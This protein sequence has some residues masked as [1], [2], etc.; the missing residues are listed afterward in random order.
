MHRKPKIAFAGFQHETNTFAPFL[1]EFS[2]FETPGAWPAFTEGEP[3]KTIC[4]GLNVPISG[5]MEANENFELIPLTYAAAE[6]G[7]LVTK[8]AF[9]RISNSIIE[10][11]KNSG[12]LDGLYFDLH[13][14]MVTEGF[15]DGEEELLKRVR[16]LVGPKMPIVASLD[17]HGNISPK[18]I[19]LVSAV[20]I[21]RT[22]PHID[23]A[24]TGRRAAALL[25]QV[26]AA[27]AP[28]FKAF[29]QANF[30]IPITAQ[31]TRR[32]PAGELYKKLSTLEKEGV[33]SVD[34]A[35]GFPP[36][37]IPNCGI[38]I[39]ACGTNK[40]AVDR[41]ADEML[42][43]INNF[44]SSFDDQLISAD[45]AVLQAR[46]LA[47]SAT[48]PIVIADPQDNPGAGATGDSTGL[49]ATFLKHKVPALLGVFWDPKAAELCHK[50]GK[51]S[52]ITISLGGKFPN[53]NG[54]ALEVTGV[55]KNI[56]DGRFT[57]TGPM[58]LNVKANLGKM[59]ALHIDLEDGKELIIVIGSNRAQNADQAF[60]KHLGYDPKE[61]GI[62]AVKSA[63]H[64]LAD[65]EPIA[66]KILFAVAP[67]QN[68]CK[69]D[70]IKYTKLRPGVR[71]GINGKAF[72]ID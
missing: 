52:E 8:N 44:E 20:T 27:K 16:D 24:M 32:E 63:V 23:M 55:V 53:D 45:Q 37:D 2:N 36:A 41:A 66:H 30:L 60:F 47:K 14:A 62:V 39:F 13:G 70:Q 35:F 38:S 67:G 54:P 59:A 11:I 72:A 57:C 5:F 21:Y 9:D 17:L 29:K 33:L 10:G 71:L 1:T 19:D 31:S 40:E 25:R 6:P 69:I 64:F 15:D 56:S 7:G 49:L 12:P 48:S 42:N 18:F 61:H 26:L 34:L 58:F 46:E 3:I 51:G 65:Y 22:Y 50:A 43:S 68:P 4:A 28:I